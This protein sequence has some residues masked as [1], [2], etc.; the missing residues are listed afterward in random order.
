LALPFDHT[1]GCLFCRGGDLE[2]AIEWV[3]HPGRWLDFFDYKTGEIA[4]V[5]SRR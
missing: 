5:L 2:T 3:P 4:V 1:G